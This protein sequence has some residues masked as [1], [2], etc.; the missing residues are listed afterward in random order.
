MSNQPGRL[1]FEADAVR[2][3]DSDNHKS[4]LRQDS[5]LSLVFGLNAART[6][7]T[8]KRATSKSFS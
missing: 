4:T 5:S 3:S 6:P 7:T 8:A 2:T 1:G